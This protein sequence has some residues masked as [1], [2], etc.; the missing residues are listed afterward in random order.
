MH[1]KNYSKYFT[2]KQTFVDYSVNIK[3]GQHVRLTVFAQDVYIKEAMP[4]TVC[5]GKQCVYRPTSE[6]IEKLCRNAL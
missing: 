6:T 4:Q 3:Y 1:Y 5:V 2:K